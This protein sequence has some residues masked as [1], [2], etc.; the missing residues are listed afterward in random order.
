ML[1]LG[2]KLGFGIRRV[3]EA[4]EFELSIDL[5]PLPAVL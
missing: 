2:K 4:S 1:A 3:P 5:D